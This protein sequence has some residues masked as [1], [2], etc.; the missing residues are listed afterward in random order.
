MAYLNEMSI[1]SKSSVKKNG[2]MS[3]NNCVVKKRNGKIWWLICG[4]DLLDSD[5]ESFQNSQDKLHNDLPNVLAGHYDLESQ[6]IIY[7][8]TNITNFGL[9]SKERKMSITKLSKRA[10]QNG[11]NAVG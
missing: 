4:E 11:Q 9:F 8:P 10:V 2:G 5:V 1:K 7:N 3:L 6:C